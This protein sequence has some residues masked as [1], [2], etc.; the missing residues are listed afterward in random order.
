MSDQI[1]PGAL[2]ATDEAIIGLLEEDG[3]LTHRGIAAQ[4]GLSRSAAATRVQRLLTE[5]HIDVRGVVHAAVLGH[6]VLAHVSVSVNGSATRIARA[7]AA[8]DDTT[9]V[10]MTS[11]HHALVLELRAGTIVQ[12]DDALA[13]VRAIDGIVAAETLLYTEV[14]RDVAAP[15]G[16]APAAGS[17]DETD[18][19]LLRALQ[20]NGRASYVDLAASVGLS[21]AGTRRRVVQLLAGNV[22]RVGAVVRH[23]GHERRTAT[24][25]G[26]R[27]DGAAHRPVAQQVADLPS[28][29]FV[30]RTLGRFDALLTV[31]TATSGDLVEVLDH[32]RDLD[33]VREAETWSHLRFVKET[34][35][36]LHL[37]G[38]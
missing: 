5:G 2:D 4:V 14:I 17:L 18:Y 10:S 27:I 24:G 7:A 9:L 16:P 30:A 3:R 26:L 6:E 20:S 29:T 33:G 28:V 25:I 11:G 8:R 37:G 32:I 21:P 34:Y 38:A 1:A 31:T 35:A 22:V 15:V 12:I 23:S 19:A 36:S 13:E